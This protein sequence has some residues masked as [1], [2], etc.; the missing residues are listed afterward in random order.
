V[1]KVE[2]TYEEDLKAVK[3]IKFKDEFENELLKELQIST[4]VRKLKD[5]RVVKYGQFWIENSLIDK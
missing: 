4:V 2:R 1:F 5:E 3:K